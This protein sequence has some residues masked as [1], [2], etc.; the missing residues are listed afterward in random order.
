MMILRNPHQQFKSKKAKAARKQR[1]RKNTCKEVSN[2]NSSQ[3][4]FM[5]SQTITTTRHNSM[6]ITIISIGIQHLTDMDRNNSFMSLLLRN[7]G[8]NNTTS[9]TT[10][11]ISKENPYTKWITI[12]TQWNRTNPRK[13]SANSLATS[14]FPQV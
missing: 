13:N 6:T 4:S 5:G 3:V 7:T 9:Q 2:M 11:N 14:S 12:A 10:C 8:S 1:K